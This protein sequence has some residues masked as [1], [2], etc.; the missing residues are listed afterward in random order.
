MARR[1]GI[2][3]VVNPQKRGVQAGAAEL[4]RLLAAHRNIRVAGMSTARNADLSRL[5]ADMVLALGG[6]GTVLSVCRRMAERQLP[7]LGIKFGHKGFLA[8]VLPD[9]MAEACARLAAGRY[10]VSPRQRI[11]AVVLRKGRRVADYVALNDVVVHS[12]PVAR[13]IF[14]GVR[15]DG[16]LVASYDA[17]GVIASTPTGSTAYSLAAG[18][19]IVAPDLDAAVITPICAHTLAARSMVVSGASTVEVRAESRDR[20]AAMTVDGQELVRIRNGDVIRLRRSKH[21]FMLVELGNRARYQAIRENLHW[22]PG[23]KGR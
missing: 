18:G 4:R 21:P 2:H 13:V 14:V 19:P 3:I 16:E 12:G 1:L 6:D 5:P 23:T 7:V 22:A 9:E 17:D 15:V 11:E 8:E 10:E 20:D